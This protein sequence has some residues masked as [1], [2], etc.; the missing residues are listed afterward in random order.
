MECVGNHTDPQFC[1]VSNHRWPYGSDIH[2]RVIRLLEELDR[3]SRLVV[4]L[5]LLVLLVVVV[6]VTP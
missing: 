4:F 5:V 6:V 2:H 3:R 1:C